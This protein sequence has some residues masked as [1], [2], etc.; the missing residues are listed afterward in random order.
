MVLEGKMSITATEM[1]LGNGRGGAYRFFSTKSYKME[2]R[3]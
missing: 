3:I 1:R 2:I